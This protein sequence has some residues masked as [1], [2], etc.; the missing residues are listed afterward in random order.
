M[1]SKGATTM[2][3]GY[4]ARWI[5]K[6]RRNA[7]LKSRPVVKWL[8]VDSFNGFIVVEPVGSNLGDGQVLAP[9]VADCEIRAAWCQD[10]RAKLTQAR[11][12]LHLGDLSAGVRSMGVA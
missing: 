1:R 8:V 2:R 9:D 7:L 4:Q 6:D 12:L 11:K 3:R 5:S 10:S